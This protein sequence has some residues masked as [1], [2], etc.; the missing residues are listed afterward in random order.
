[1]YRARSKKGRAQFIVPLQN[2]KKSAY[3]NTTYLKKIDKKIDK[4]IKK[5]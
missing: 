4:I 3:C 2:H 5:Q 1:M